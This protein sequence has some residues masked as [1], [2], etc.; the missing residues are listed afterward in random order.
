MTTG[1]DTER[2]TVEL[3]A[4]AAGWLTVYRRADAQIRHMEEVKAEARRHLEEA[5][6][7]AELGTVDGDVA[8]RWTFIES[9]RLDQKK[10]KEQAPE[11]VEQCTVASTSRRFSLP[12]LP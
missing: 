8:V 1:T 5:L 10:L 9:R 6:G 11:L 4:E 7:D 2:L 12:D 3:A